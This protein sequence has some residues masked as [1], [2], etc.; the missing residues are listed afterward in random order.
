MQQGKDKEMFYVKVVALVF[1]IIAL[2]YVLGHKPQ[3][4]EVI[5]TRQTETGEE[6][7]AV[8][9]VEEA[10]PEPVELEIVVPPK[11]E[12]VPVQEEPVQQVV[13]PATLEEDL[14]KKHSIPETLQQGMKDIEEIA[15]DLVRV[16]R[17]MSDGT[18]AYYVY[19]PSKQET[20]Q[21]EDGTFKFVHNSKMYYFV[22]G[23]YYEYEKFKIFKIEDEINRLLGRNLN[24]RESN[25]LGKIIYVCQVTDTSFIALIGSK[26]SYD[27]AQLYFFDEEV[28]KVRFLSIGEDEAEELGKGIECVS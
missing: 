28:D 25:E 9:Q 6:R 17:Q 21:I 1:L 3:Q 14:V 27:K 18:F 26:T 10:L 16:E 4:E 7:T 11:E 5:I 22:N 15:P 23:L 20:T 24:Y 8:I 2:V 12:V 19:V 13:Q